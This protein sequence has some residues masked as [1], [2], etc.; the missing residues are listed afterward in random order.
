MPETGN[1]EGSRLR[2]CLLSNLLVRTIPRSSCVSTENG[3]REKCSVE[4]RQPYQ[5]K[6]A[7]V[8]SVDFNRT[9]PKIGFIS[10]KDKRSITSLLKY[11]F[12]ST[13]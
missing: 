9:R 7:M 13:L 11:I 8:E 5:P 2:A 4:K 10:G 6:R 1:F 12:G 3:R